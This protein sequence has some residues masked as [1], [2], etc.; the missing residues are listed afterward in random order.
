MSV[1]CLGCSLHYSK[2]L[3]T[4]LGVAELTSKWVTEDNKL[5]YTGFSVAG[6]SQFKI[7]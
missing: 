7:N 2:Y 1:G 3:D 4:V 5:G 6:A